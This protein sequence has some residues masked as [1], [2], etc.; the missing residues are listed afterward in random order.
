[1]T[2]LFQSIGDVL[3]NHKYILTHFFNDEISITKQPR[4]NRLKRHIIFCKFFL[5]YFLYFY[6]R[7][8]KESNYPYT[9]TCI[10]FDVTN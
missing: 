4:S 5:N 8:Y 9:R 1:M 6:V 2:K 10:T 3:Y 7:N